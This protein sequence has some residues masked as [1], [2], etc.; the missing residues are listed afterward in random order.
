[1]PAVAHDLEREIDRVPH[2]FQSG[3]PARPQRGAFHQAGVKLHHTIKVEAR[4][5]ARVEEWLVFHEPDRRD[6][7][8]QGAVTDRRPTGVARALNSSLPGWAFLLGNRPRAAVDDQRGPGQRRLVVLRLRPELVALGHP[9]LGDP[10]VEWKDT[11]AAGG[12]SLRSASFG[13]PALHTRTPL[14]GSPFRFT[15]HC[16][17]AQNHTFLSCRHWSVMLSHAMI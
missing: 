14:A 6:D 9:P 5:N 11:A 13:K 12:R 3:D 1:M 8:G 10:A 16:H 15:W 7:R 2:I 4:S 17:I